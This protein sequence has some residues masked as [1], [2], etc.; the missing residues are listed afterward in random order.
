M[1]QL[2]KSIK[3]IVMH[4]ERKYIFVKDQILDRF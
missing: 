3:I 2:K 4:S 1:K